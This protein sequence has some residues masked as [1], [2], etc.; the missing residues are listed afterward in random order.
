MA[1]SR[2]EILKV[3]DAEVAGVPPKH[4]DLTDEEIDAVVA[5]VCTKLPGVTQDD[6]VN[7]LRSSSAEEE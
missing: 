7:A 3:W 6:I 5:T 2:D 1:F 4:L